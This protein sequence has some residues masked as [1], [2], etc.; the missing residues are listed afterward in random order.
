MS[1]V[2]RMIGTVVNEGSKPRRLTTIQVTRVNNSRQ[3][4]V[5]AIIPTPANL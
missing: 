5:I 4:V 2:R 1:L 3:T